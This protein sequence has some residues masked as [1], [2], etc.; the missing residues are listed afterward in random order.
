MNEKTFNKIFVINSTKK[1]NYEN[2]SRL[3]CTS[4]DLNFKLTIDVHNIF[5]E[6]QPQ[7]PNELWK[8]PLANGYHTVFDEQSKK[9]LCLHG[10]ESCN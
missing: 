7:I 2:V 1:D 3:F 5:L 9:Y 8:I 6:G 4:E 10:E